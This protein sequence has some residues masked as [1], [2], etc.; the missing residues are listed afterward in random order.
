[1]HPYFIFPLGTD[2]TISIPAYSFFACIG[3]LCMM[4]FLYFRTQAAGIPYLRYLLLIGYMVAGVGIGSKAVLYFTVGY[5]AQLQARQFLQNSF[6]SHFKCSQT[7]SHRDSRCFISGEES[8]A[9]SQ[10]A[11]TES[12]LSGELQWWK[13][14][15]HLAF[16]SS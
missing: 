2:W 12:R 16:P 13:T 4:L 11:A 10:A 1:M 7:S 3:L 6:K 8:D 5:L 15:A 14:S 9:S